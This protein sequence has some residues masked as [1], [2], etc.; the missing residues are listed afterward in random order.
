MDSLLAGHTR[1]AAWDRTEAVEQIDVEADPVYV[2]KERVL[3]E[4]LNS[5][6]CSEDTNESYHHIHHSWSTKRSR[7]RTT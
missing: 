4:I 5:M 7:T 2:T 1:I 6:T 3:V